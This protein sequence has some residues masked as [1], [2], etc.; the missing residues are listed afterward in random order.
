MIEQAQAIMDELNRRAALDPQLRQIMKKIDRGKA[1]FSDTSLLSQRMG[2]LLG[3][4]FSAEVL[5]IPE[6]AREA[7]CEDLL[8]GQYDFTNETLEAVQEALD[9]SQGLHLTPQRAAFPAERVEQLAHSLIDP[10]VKPET[11]R[12]RADKPVATV[13]KSF[14][15]DYIK[16]NAKLRAQLGMKPTITRYGTGCCAWCSAVAGKYRFGEQPDDIFR[17]HDNCD[18][19]VIYDNQVLRGAKTEGGGRSRTWE[20]VDPAEV[21]RDGFKPGVFSEREAREPEETLLERLTL[22]GERGIIKAI[23]V[24]DILSAGIIDKQQPSVIKADVAK[25]II[26]TISAAKNSGGRFAFDD[27]RV[28]SIPKNDDRGMV[29]F[30]TNAV[31][32]FGYPHVILEINML[33]IG[34]LDVEDVDAIFSQA[35]NTE[36]NSLAEGI[37]HEIGHAK[38]I[39]GRTFANYERISEDL[40]DVHIDSISALAKKDGLELIA[41]SEVILSRGGT[42]PPDVMEIYNTYTT[43]GG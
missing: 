32:R 13:A 33:A 35:E 5:D 8:R 42:L 19:V 26:D 14:H 37:I 4:L 21:M 43:G 31:D 39:Y 6:D 23:T 41:E 18:C 11:I 17:R 38:T 1:D 20:E 12:R 9:A 10:T 34:D 16:T 29:V 7:V 15:D 28:V 24:D 27:V 40:E 36:C 2:N 25:A 22:S 30:Q 3:A